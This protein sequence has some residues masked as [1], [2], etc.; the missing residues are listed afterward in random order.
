MRIRR[1]KAKLCRIVS[2]SSS[3]GYEIGKLPGDDERM[4]NK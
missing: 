3:V 4:S 1:H 2:A